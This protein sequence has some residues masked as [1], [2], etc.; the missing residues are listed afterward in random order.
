[1]NRL[2]SQYTR[3]HIHTNLQTCTILINM[4]TLHAWRT[5]R[6]INKSLHT[7]HT[8]IQTH[9][10][11]IHTLH[12]YIRTFARIETSVKDI[13]TLLHTYTHLRTDILC[14]QHRLTYTHTYTRAY[15]QHIHTYTHRM[16]TLL[17]KNSYITSHAVTLHHIT[18]QYST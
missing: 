15:K 11:Y 16:H 2:H 1:M 14:V 12:A 9:I 13:H 10:T 6:Y 7:V 8:H 5:L 17:C 3:T 18:L 4:Q